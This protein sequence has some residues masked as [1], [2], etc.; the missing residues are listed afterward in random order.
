MG[1]SPAPRIPCRPDSRR[2]YNLSSY[3]ESYNVSTLVSSNAPVVI[4]ERAMYGNNRTWAHDSIGVTTP[5]TAWYLAEGCTGG[6]F[7]TWVLVQNPGDT[8]VTVDLSYMIDGRGNRR[9]PGLPSAPLPP[10][11]QRGL[12]P[13]TESYNV[14][15]HGKLHRAPVICERAVYGNNRTWAH[16]SI[17]VT[18]PAPTWYLAEGCTRTRLRDLRTGAEPRRHRRHRGPDLHD[19]GGGGIAG[20]QDYRPS[21]PARAITFRVNDSVDRLGRLHHGHQRQAGHL[22]AGHVRRKPHL[23][24]RLHRRH[25]PRLDLVPG[26]G[27]HGSRLRVLGA[28]AEP[29]RHQRHNR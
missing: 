12:L 2:S 22:R 1:K 11:L 15:T 18:A 23:G 8:D 25:R 5:A 26:R 16:D 13:V 9:P 24:P 17:G 7:E 14:S 20:P 3:L 19:S 29:R 27:L 21:R 10:L 4:C 28:G 6:G